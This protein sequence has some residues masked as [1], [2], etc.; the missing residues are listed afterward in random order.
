ELVY[1]K[2]PA[3]LSG[4]DLVTNSGQVRPVD[5]TMVSCLK[6]SCVV[7]LMY[8]AWEYRSADVDLDACRSRGIV[9]A[10]TN[11]KHPAVDVFSFLGLMAVRQL[12]DAGIAVHGCHIL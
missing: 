1:E 9:V 5:K 12:H 11:E 3:I 8:E 7:P 6:P 4:I 10:G 2:S